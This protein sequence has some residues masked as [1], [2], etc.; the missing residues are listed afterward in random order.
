MRFYRDIENRALSEESLHGRMSFIAGPRQIGKTTLIQGFL[1][2]NGQEKLYYNWDTPSVKRRFAGKSDFFIEDVA[3]EWEKPWVAFDEI[4]KYPKWKNIL[5]G[6]YDEYK[7]RVHFVIT[8]S[9]KLDHFRKSGDSLVGRYFLFKMLPLGVKELIHQNAWQ[10]AGW[11]PQQKFGVIPQADSKIKE[12]V[13]YL[14]R[15]TGFPEPLAVGTEDFCQRWR[16]NYITLILQEDLRDLTK[17]IQIKKLETLLFLLPERVGSPLSLNA[18]CQV[19]ECAHGSMRSWLSALELVYLI[20]AVT[21]WTGRLSRSV[22]KEKKYYFWDTGMVTD[23]GKR[24]ENFLA[25]Q[26]QRMIAMWNEQGKGSFQLFYLRTKDG[27]EVD[28]AIADRRQIWFIVEAKE[29]EKTLSPHLAYFRQKIGD[30]PAFQVIHNYEV[31]EQKGGNIYLIGIDRFL[32]F[33]P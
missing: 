27:R 1:K 30:I 13:E 14:L 2:E 11:A 18:L 9:A 33:L 8:G 29:T 15:L 4:H 20:F 12:G 24:F 28:F 22:R 3:L 10:D 7:E 6:Y 17:I 21:P 23:P 32:N 16:D 19:L 5:K 31:S 25:V 26:L